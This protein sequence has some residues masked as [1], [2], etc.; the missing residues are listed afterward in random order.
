MCPRDR[1]GEFES[2]WLPERKGQD[3]ETEAF[4]AEAFL[5]GLSTRDL[6]RISEKHL[7]QKYDSKQVS[8]IV[9][10]AT[11]ELEAWRQRPLTERQ[12][13]ISVYRWGQLSGADQRLGQSPEFLCGVGGQ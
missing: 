13:Q 11:R 3:P 9:A 8:R 12:L 4:L 10:R 7:G 6:A 5:A 1:K 2:A